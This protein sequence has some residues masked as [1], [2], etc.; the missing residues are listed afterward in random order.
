MVVDN[1]RRISEQNGQKVLTLVYFNLRCGAKSTPRI[2][3][4]FLT[5]LGQYD[6]K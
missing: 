5:E 2:L 1:L 3:A 4:A 6:G